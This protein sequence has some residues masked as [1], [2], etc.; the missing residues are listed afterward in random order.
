MNYFAKIKEN[1]KSIGLITLLAL[2][3]SVIFTFIQPFEYGSTFSLMVIEKSQNLDAYSAAKSAERLSNS[4]ARVIY[5]TSFYDKVAS[6]GY[7]SKD[8]ILN[9]DEAKKREQWKHQIETRVMPEVGL[10]KISVYNQDKN[11]ANSVAKA[12]A[13]VL[14]ENGVEYLGGGNSIILKIVDYPLTS[15][16]PV[17]PNIPL[18]LAAGFI[19]GF[20]GSSG[21]HILRSMTKASPELKKVKSTGG[22]KEEKSEIT[23]E[24][25]ERQPVIKKKNEFVFESYY[26]KQNKIEEVGAVNR[27][28]N[29]PEEHFQ[30]RRI[31]TLYDHVK[32]IPEPGQPPKKWNE[33]EEEF[34]NFE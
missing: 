4:L 19:I 30:D 28:K 32:D 24:I 3:I 21:Y 17:R 29:H 13:M 10:V 34:R 27:E 31:K 26:P 8:T 23:K 11:K 16:N 7:L 14:S 20:V 1:W 33:P 25:D 9:G 22:L 12:L 18:N 2:A 6:S 15:N 5:T